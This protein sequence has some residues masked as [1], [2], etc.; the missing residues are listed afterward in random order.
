VAHGDRSCEKI[1]AVAV[2]YDRRILESTTSAL[3]ERRY[4]FQGRNFRLADVHGNV[5]EKMWA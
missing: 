3:I 1:L 4:K 5:M 2:V